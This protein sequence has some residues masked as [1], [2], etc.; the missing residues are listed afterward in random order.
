MGTAIATLF[1]GGTYDGSGETAEDKYVWSDGTRFSTGYT[2]WKSGEPNLDSVHGTDLCVVVQSAS[3]WGFQ[4]NDDGC[5]EI[6][7]S[8]CEVPGG[9]W[10]SPPPNPPPN[11]PPSPPPPAPPLRVRRRRPR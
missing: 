5:N 10:N 8:I 4:W 1:I 2:N 9:Q 7:A 11:P 3:Y 6:R